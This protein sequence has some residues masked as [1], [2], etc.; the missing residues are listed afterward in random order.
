MKDY[1]PHLKK[2]INDLKGKNFKEIFDNALKIIDKNHKKK[3]I[4]WVGW[5]DSWIEEFFPIFN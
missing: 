4:K 5:M 1:V 3:N 2:N